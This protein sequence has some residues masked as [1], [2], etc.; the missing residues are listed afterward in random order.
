MSHGDVDY[1][2]IGGGVSVSSRL[3]TVF[4]TNSFGRRGP[5]WALLILPVPCNVYISTR[6]YP[7]HTRTHTPPPPARGWF[8]NLHI[9]WCPPPPLSPSFP[10]HYYIVVFDQEVIWECKFLRIITTR[11]RAPP[12][13]GGWKTNGEK[14]LSADRGI[15]A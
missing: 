2:I 8:W 7:P 4:Y 14:K 9:V 12:P 3:C 10:P 15:I 6:V 11:A 13:K 1:N 5:A